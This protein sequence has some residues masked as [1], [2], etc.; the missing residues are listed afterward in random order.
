MASVVSKMVLISATLNSYTSFKNRQSCCSR[1]NDFEMQVKQ[2]AM[3]SF[4]S[5]CPCGE[6]VLM[7]IASRKNCGSARAA[8][9]PISVT[10]STQRFLA[11][12]LSFA[13]LE[14]IANSHVFTEDCPLNVSS[15][16]VALINVSCT[17]SSASATLAVIR[18]IKDFNCPVDCLN[19]FVSCS[20]VIGR[21]NI[22]AQDRKI[23]ARYEGNCY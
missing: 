16:S 22:A 15:L 21:F 19:S 3:C 23:D 13:R 17:I 4:I 11:L 9:F 5:N 6:V 20:F 7:C 10:F 14:A 8:S 12:R 1:G 18:R 2:K